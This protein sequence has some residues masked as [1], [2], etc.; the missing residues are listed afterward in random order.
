MA[1]Y[2]LRRQQHLKSDLQSVWEFV[3]SPANLKKITPA[4]MGFDIVTRHMPAQMYEG[5]IIEYNV[6]PFPMYRARWVTEI[7]HI[8]QGQYFVD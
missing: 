5:M 6:K 1:F 4:S 8:K 2:Q 3:A 7:T